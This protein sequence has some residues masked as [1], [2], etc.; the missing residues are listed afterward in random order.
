MNKDQVEGAAEEGK[1]KIKEVAGDLTG[2]KSL[3]AE[4]QVDQVKGKVQKNYGDAKEDVKDTIDK[5]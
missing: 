1:G 5:L 2:N 3:E 4:G